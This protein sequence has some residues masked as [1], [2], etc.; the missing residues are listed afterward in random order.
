MAVRWGL[1]F[2]NVG[3]CRPSSLCSPAAARGAIALLCQVDSGVAAF[4]HLLLT[5]LPAEAES[6]VWS[7][8]FPKESP[9]QPVKGC[10]DMALAKAGCL[11]RSS[12]PRALVKNSPPACRPKPGVEG[13]EHRARGHAGSALK[14]RQSRGQR[15]ALFQGDARH[16]AVKFPG[17][18]PEGRPLRLPYRCTLVPILLGRSGVQG[19]VTGCSLPSQLC[20]AC[21][22][23]PSLC[24]C[25]P[26]PEGP[27]LAF[28]FRLPEGCGSKKAKSIGGLNKQPRSGCPTRRSGDWYSLQLLVLNLDFHSTR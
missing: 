7:R 19:G 10:C 26:G 27:L 25:L 2:D 1:E 17:R 15:Q 21:W 14:P 5:S 6:S 24:P 4:A 20:R 3:R 9:C 11:V 12:L 13:P 8:S 23:R 22:S 18:L 16:I 28:P